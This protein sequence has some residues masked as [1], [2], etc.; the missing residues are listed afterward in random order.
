MSVYMAGAGRL[1]SHDDSTRIFLREGATVPA[2]PDHDRPR[3]RDATHTRQLLLDTAR[4]HFA[5]H[6]FA[7]TTVRDIADG[8]GVNVALIN[9][10]FTSKEGLFEACLTSAVADLRSEP[11]RSSPTD[12]AATMAHRIV[13]SAGDKRT[14]DSL[15]LLV[16]TSGDERTEAMR[17]AFVRSI[18]E[19][20][21]GATGESPPTEPAVLRA[22]ILLGTVL[23]ATLLRTS[24]GVPPLAT[25]D[26][27]QIRDALSAV[28][29]TLL[30]PAAA[31]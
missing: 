16:R 11:D 12:I 27:E 3:R 20:L 18:S 29:E 15:L 28:I 10:Y 14:H 22:Q 2:D 31:P 13:G 21:A 6:G 23:G 5:R 30:P 24:I 8:A 9:R 7:T 17:S 26:E 19:R 25:A 4:H 1:G